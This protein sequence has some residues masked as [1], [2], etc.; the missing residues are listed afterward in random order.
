METIEVPVNV[1]WFLFA[2][3]AL[4]P[5]AATGLSLL[6]H[7]RVWRIREMTIRGEAALDAFKE[8]KRLRD[9]LFDTAMGMSLGSRTRRDDEELH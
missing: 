9:E 7:K 5:L 1:M 8:N 4:G 3:I 6:F 2:M